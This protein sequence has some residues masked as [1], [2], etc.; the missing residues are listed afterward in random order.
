MKLSM[1][2][3]F[4]RYWEQHGAEQ[5]ALYLRE[6]GLGGAEILSNAHSERTFAPSLEEARELR[7]IFE[8][9]EIHFSC[10]S[11]GADLL[12]YPE[13]AVERLCYFAEVAAVLGSPYLHHTL[14]PFLSLPPHAPSFQDALRLILPHARYVADYA[15]NLGVTCLYEPQGMFIN[16]TKGM[17]AFWEA[18]SSF[19]GNVGICGDVGNTLFVD[20]SPLDFFA[21]FAT[22]I[23]H[24]H[25]K[26]YC[27]ASTEETY[28]FSTRSGRRITECSL[29]QGEIPLRQCM[30][31]LYTAGYRGDLSLKNLHPKDWSRGLQEDI[32]YT[33]KFYYNKE[34]VAFATR[35]LLLSNYL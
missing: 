15:S 18:I 14:I 35:S 28:V 4:T 34:R 6:L 17:S 11:V 3:G 24:V 12:S 19:C 20:E 7:E 31:L 32:A 1:Y 29:G 13:Q 22:E 30:D 23:R 25:P 2:T 8:A 10:Y 9:H 5:T 33:K 21:L 26:D 16:G 27:P